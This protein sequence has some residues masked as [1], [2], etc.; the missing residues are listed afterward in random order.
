MTPTS[1]LFTKRGRISFDAD[2]RGLGPDDVLE[3]AIEVGAEDVD[4]DE[5]GNIIL[6]TE[7]SGTNAAAQ[8]LASKMDLK[9]GTMGVVWDA[10]EETMVEIQ[11]KDIRPFVEFLA[12]VR[13]EPNV[14]GVYANVRKGGLS[15][16]VW[17]E[18][19]SLLD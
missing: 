6:W 11:E 14:I 2:E 7:P 9:I 17:E 19:E 13:E 16:E 3:E 15:D 8:G 18:V 12:R 10:N 4:G 5:E 1:Y